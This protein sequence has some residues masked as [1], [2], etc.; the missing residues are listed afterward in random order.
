MASIMFENAEAS[1]AF[2][3]AINRLADEP[4]KQMK[5]GDRVRALYELKAI[6]I[7]GE[8]PTFQITLDDIRRLMRSL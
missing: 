8:Y 6:S 4:E 1:K 3:D 2:A 5:L 7:E